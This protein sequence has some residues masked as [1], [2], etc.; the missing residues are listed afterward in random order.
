MPQP[1]EEHTILWAPVLV[2]QENSRDL[3]LTRS[4]AMTRPGRPPVIPGVHAH[5]WDVEAV[6]IPVWAD[7]R[8]KDIRLRAEALQLSRPSAVVSHA[9]AALIHGWPLPDRLVAHDIHVTCP[10]T[11]VRRRGFL[12]HVADHLRFVDRYRIVVAHPLDTLRQLAG[13]VDSR[14]LLDVLDTVCGSWHGPAVTTPEA[15]RL[16]VAEWPRF[17][18]RAAMD[19][20]LRY[21]R[22]GV[23]SPRETALRLAIIGAGLPEPNV[24]AP[25]TIAGRTYHPDLSYPH[26]RIAIEYEGSHHLTARRQWNVDIARER[27]FNDHGW[28]YIRVTAD[29]DVAEFLAYLR[30]RIAE[31]ATAPR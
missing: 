5:R 31:R 20:A 3:G 16:A 10:R 2:T 9:S 11:R 21:A 18:G 4:A 14:E 7:E 6:G 25:V 30:T 17:R 8:W 27:D 22:A 29:T 15:L 24:T 1:A 28:V 13:L 19:D 23:G 26:L 12:G